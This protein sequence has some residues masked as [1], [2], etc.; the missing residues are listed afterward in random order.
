LWL[1][2]KTLKK[3]PTDP[4]VK[5][6]TTFQIEWIVENIVLDSK[7]EADAYKRAS[8]DNSIEIDTSMDIEEIDRLNLQGINDLNSED[9]TIDNETQEQIDFIKQRIK[10]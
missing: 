5:K 3:L 9:N 1:V 10:K 6:L 7:L 2:C 8:G 4:L